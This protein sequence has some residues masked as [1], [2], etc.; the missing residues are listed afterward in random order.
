MA[1]RS[2]TK[3]G[4][5]WGDNHPAAHSPQWHLGYLAKSYRSKLISFRNGSK[6]VSDVCLTPKR[7][8][9]LHGFRSKSLRRPWKR[10]N[11]PPLDQLVYIEEVGF[12]AKHKLVGACFG[13]WILFFHILR[14]IILTYELIF[15]SETTN[16]INISYSLSNL[17][18]PELTKSNLI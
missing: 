15:F 2:T 6:C 8:L 13:T 1:A 3:A 11:R 17:I 16:Q 9:H 14:I 7:W 18:Q 12:F 10:W 4:N 5:V